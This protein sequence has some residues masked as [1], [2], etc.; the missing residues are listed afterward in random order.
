MSQSVRDAIA[1]KGGWNKCYSPWQCSFHANASA[2]PD[3]IPSS[4]VLANSNG[5]TALESTTYILFYQIKYE[6]FMFVLMGQVLQAT[7]GRAAT[8][9][10]P[11]FVDSGANEGLWS[12]LA[13]SHGCHVIS[14]EPQPGCHAWIKKSLALNPRAE[15]HVHLW[16][17]F[18]SANT[19]TT[20]E[21]DAESCFGA[22][23]LSDSRDRSSALA[24]SQP[25]AH[26]GGATHR[27]ASVSA[28]RL[29]ESAFLHVHR[30]DAHIALWHLDTE[31][32]EVPVLRSASALFDADRIDRVVLEVTP[33][34]WANYRVSLSVG[35]AELA[36]RFGT[37]QCMWACTGV[38]IDWSKEEERVSKL[39]L[40]GH[41]GHG[42]HCSA[43]WNRG[44]SAVD[45][46][47]VRPGVA[48]LY[49]PT[50]TAALL[51]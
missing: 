38:I 33:R 21:V 40:H 20:L 34:A 32:A 49:S 31:G 44:A 29:D 15:R 37:W 2:V 30:P 43:P 6:P 1:S 18:L 35:Y 9:R 50:H 36:R 24:G 5:T 45:A 7:C 39:I 47:C 46:Y 11:V 25:G 8:G 13:G 17:N 23:Q 42:G 12:L 27:R 3:Y 51:K 19:T 41:K 26:R 4:L 28:A 48:P 14:V 22:E 16:H 10:S